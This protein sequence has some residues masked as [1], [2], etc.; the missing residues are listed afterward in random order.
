MGTKHQIFP[1]KELL[2]Q[3]RSEIREICRRYA[4]HSL[5]LFGSIA[6]GKGHRD[7]D[8]DILV[9]FKRPVG[10]FHLVRLERELSKLLGVTVDLV[11][12]KSLSPYIRTQVMASSRVLYESA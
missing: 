12:E 9:R 8:I 4:V 5:R 1:T 2:D 6:L 11:T 3:N 10:F 7:S